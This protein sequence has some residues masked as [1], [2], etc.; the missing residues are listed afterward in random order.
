MIQGTGGLVVS[1]V[2][3][4]SKRREAWRLS[5]YLLLFDEKRRFYLLTIYG[6]NEMSESTAAPKETTKRLLWRRGAM[7]NRDLFAE[8]SSALVEAKEEYSEG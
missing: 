2:A 3:S 1:R 5:S 4:K 8:L 6:K 7:S